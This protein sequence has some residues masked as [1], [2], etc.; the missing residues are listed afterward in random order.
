MYPPRQAY[1]PAE[2][3]ALDDAISASFVEGGALNLY[4]HFPFCRQI[5]G[6]CNLY[7]V[8]VPRQDQIEAYLTAIEADIVAWGRRVPPSRIR[9]IYF[10]G[11]TPS[12][13]KAEQLKR[14]LD[15]LCTTFNCRLAE[16]E[17]V[18]IEVSPETV[19]AQGY[20][21]LRAAGFD[22]VNLGVQTLSDEEL[23][24]FGR[25]YDQTVAGQ[26]V[27]DAV[28]SGFSNVC[29][30]LIFG[31]SGQTDRS[32]IQSVG[33]VISLR[34]QTICTYALTTRPK[35]GYA[36]RGYEGASSSVLYGRYDAARALLA[37][38]GYVAE[39]HVRYVSSSAGGYRQ[40]A[41]HWAGENVLG[42][43]AGARSYLRFCDFQNGYSLS[44]RRK[45]L[46]KYMSDVLSG[47]SPIT[48]AYL[49][50]EDE[51]RRKRLI[52]G[53]FNLDRRAYQEEFGGDVL[54]HFPE[55]LKAMDDIGL[56]VIDGRSI[57]L[58]ES[59]ARIRDNLVQQFFS[60]RARTDSAS[61]DY[62]HS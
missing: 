9:T 54:D 30:D 42:F 47:Q 25:P 62:Q 41:N 35:T 61:Y 27:A 55:E 45:T 60:A 4:L 10:G 29:V 8:G 51:R 5:C 46:A 37:A 38:S 22:R 12:L 15:T 6:F 19:T 1:S 2:G 50:T 28:A 16:L 7:T 23:S 44:A 18:A 11:G 20:R 59:G 17:E 52:L 39:N 36:A 56:L 34:P 32:W 48:A 40:K 3:R 24:A 49:M 57:R 33:G 13:L 26:A 21:D 14:V 58:T 43:G 53:L 31:L